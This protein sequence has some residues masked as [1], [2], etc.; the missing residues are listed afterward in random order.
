MLLFALAW[1]SRGAELQEYRQREKTEPTTII[2]AGL[3]GKIHGR[4]GKQ[5]S[6]L[7]H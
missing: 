4:D 7:E 5:N 6:E 2:F 1:C 3:D